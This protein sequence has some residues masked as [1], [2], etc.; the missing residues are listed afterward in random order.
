MWGK[1]MSVIE[2]NNFSKNYGKTLAV[3]DI[4]LSVEKGE[5]VGFVGKNGAGKSTTIRAILNMISPSKGY[6][7]INGLNSVNDSKQIK[8]R[9]SYMTSEASFYEKLLVADLFKFCLKFS[10]EG[11]EYA[12]EL[13]NYFELDMN[14][15]ISELSLGNRK[16]VSIIQ[17]LLKKA[18]IIILDEP[19]SGLD[20]LMQNKFFDL[21]SKEKEKG[22]TIFL[23]SHNLSEVEKYCDKVAII[24]DGKIVDFLD[25]KNVKIKRQHKVSYTTDDGKNES[26]DFDGDI[27][28]LVAKISLLKLESLEIKNKTIEDEFISFYKDGEQDA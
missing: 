14:K 22:V 16:K 5:I 3:D 13:A 24:K 23:S 11:F 18:E 25:M 20:P 10:D 7:K 17:A 4:S 27:N 6:I 26:F 21:L 15:K 28:E 8:E 1:I 19:T 9:L 12:E 2:I